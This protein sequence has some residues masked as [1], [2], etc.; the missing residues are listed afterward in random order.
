MF[1]ENHDINNNYSIDLSQD[2]IEYLIKLSTYTNI[3][4]FKKK[5]N[6]WILKD[7]RIIVNECNKMKKKK[8]KNLSNDLKNKSTNE[9]K[10]DEIKDIN[11]KTI[12]DI[13]NIDSIIDIIKNH[14]TEEYIEFYSN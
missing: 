13:D 6:K 1:N 5:K 4:I 2:N 9:I 8:I 14:D 10:V 3:N 12:S 7:R 11:N